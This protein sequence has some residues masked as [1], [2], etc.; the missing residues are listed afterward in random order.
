[1]FLGQPFSCKVAG[2]FDECV[3][4]CSQH[5]SKLL[6]NN[7]LLHFNKLLLMNDF[8]IKVFITSLDNLAIPAY[9]SDTISHLSLHQR[10]IQAVHQVQCQTGS[11][12]ILDANILAKRRNS[13]KMS[14]RLGYKI[15]L[16][17]VVTELRNLAEKNSFLTWK[18]RDRFK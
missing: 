2:L 8:Q 16:H 1:M 6:M 7:F 5:S 12:Q 18:N 14:G 10:T 15:F 13:L 17:N 11:G 9:Q 4:D 3:N